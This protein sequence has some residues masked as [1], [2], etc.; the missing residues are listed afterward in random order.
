MTQP[1]HAQ[2]YRDVQASEDFQDLRK[3]FRGFVFPCT[4]FFLVWYFVYVLLAAYMPE[5]MSTVVFWNINVGLLMG[6]GQFVTTFAITIAYVRWAD[7][8]FDPKADAIKEK[9]M[10]SGDLT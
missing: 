6:L 4:I 3:R 2:S 10:G 5:F 9:M 1:D 8:V 7:K